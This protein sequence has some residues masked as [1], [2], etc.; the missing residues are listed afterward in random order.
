MAATKIVTP[1]FRLSYTHLFEPRA[2]AEGAKEKY[3][4][5]ILIPKTE[6]EFVKQFKDAVAKIMAEDPKLKGTKKGLKHPLRDGDEERESEEY[7][8]HWFISASGTTAPLVLGEDKSEIIDK[9]EIYSG[10]YGRVS[11]NLFAFD[12]AGNKGVGAGL[13]AVQKTG[14]GESLGGT[15][16]KDQAAEDFGDDIL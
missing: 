9:R 4:V 8:G 1:E 12:K 13:N 5:S 15:Y 11:M 7:A 16:T 10:M 3:S 2:M 14:D 6:K